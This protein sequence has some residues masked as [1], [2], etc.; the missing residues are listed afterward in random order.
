MAIKTAILAG[1]PYI[2]DVGVNSGESVGNTSKLAVAITTEKKETANHQGGGGNDDSF[3]RFKSGSVTLTC[4]HVS[5]AVLTKALGATA[6]TVASGVVTDEQYTV[7]AVDTLIVLNSMQDM[8]LPCTVK[9]MAGSTTYVEGT[10]YTR[11]RGGII[12]IGGAAGGIVAADTIKV[13]YTKTK[14]V[15]F[16]GLVNLIQESRLFFDGVNERSNK[17]WQGIFHRVK[18]GPAKSLDFI[19][20]DFASFEIE[21]EILAYD[22]IQAAGKSQ[23]YELLVGD[24]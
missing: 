20:E 12:P 10:H 19:T 7:V 5:L 2:S 9:N 13:S 1:T 18:W 15:R 14:H 23:F 16:Q 8:G 22:A 6:A 4:K 11:K 21:G 17:P 24:L 3:E